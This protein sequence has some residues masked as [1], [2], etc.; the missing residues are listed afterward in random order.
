MPFSHE[1]TQDGVAP[2]NHLVSAALLPIFLPSTAR[3]KLETILLPVIRCHPKEEHDDHVV[4]KSFIEK[5]EQLAPVAAMMDR[6]S[7]AKS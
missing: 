5:F 4:P 1:C 6:W 7:K 2:Y 3:I